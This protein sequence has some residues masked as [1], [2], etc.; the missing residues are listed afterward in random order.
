MF[1]HDWQLLVST[2]RYR[3]QV[4]HARDR[5]AGNAGKEL[6][7]EVEHMMES[8]ALRR[9]RNKSRSKKTTVLR[10]SKPGRRK[11][12]DDGKYV[13]KY[14]AYHRRRRRAGK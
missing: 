8:V 10:W 2:V 11:I 12:G 1:M 3:S 4:D 9:R 7:H 5:H 14:V 13:D 6:V